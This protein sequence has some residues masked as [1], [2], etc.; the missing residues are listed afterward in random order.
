[1]KSKNTGIKYCCLLLLALIFSACSSQT[2][3]V[4][5]EADTHTSGPAE[6]VMENSAQKVSPT[7][8]LPVQYQNPRYIV[9]VDKSDEIEDEIDEIGLKVGANIV[10]TRGPEPLADVLRILARSKGF[11]I[12]WA[13]DVDRDVLVDVNIGANDDFHRSIENL[14]RQVDYFHEF[15]NN[16]LI[17]KYKETRQ[18]HVAMPFTAQ[19]Y[20]TGTGGNVLGGDSSNTEVDGTIELKSDNNEFDIWKN[21]QA[22]MD[23]IIAT[24]N[25]TTI[26][27]Q[28]GV[29]PAEE[30]E[31]EDEEAEEG[32]NEEVVAQA[33]MQVSSGDSMYIIDKP[34]GL[35]T[36]S[37]PRPLLDR[38]EAYFDS[39]KR[40]LYKQVNIEAKIIE[41][42]LVNDSDI[43][44][45]WSQVLSNFAING[46]IQFGEIGGT[47]WPNESALPF[48]RSVSL[49]G[50]NF[51]VFLNA[52]KT[53]G[54][55]HIL[56]N[57]RISVMNGQPALISVG[58]NTT[59]IDAVEADRD[60]V[61]NLTYSLKT[62]RIMSGV[63]LALTANILDD[64]EIIM[65][66]VPVTSELEEPIEYRKFGGLY[67][68]GLPIVNVREMSTTVKVRNGEMLVIGGLIDS[69]EQTQGEFAPVAGNI[70]VLR[71]LFGHEKKIRQKRELI[72]LLKPTIL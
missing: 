13:S 30:T 41:V 23:A 51:D 28:T 46:T 49:S 64:K 10:S 47:V 1:M 20:K 71:Y 12:S 59:Y 19:N 26:P 15:E 54:D 63:G 4:N 17:I 21:I 69:T 68:V 7:G 48:V 58:K 11:T 25:T 53:Q 44:I 42:Q 52:L 5:S 72:V 24:W 61:G 36:V 6:S 14:L 55:T 37:A 3:T 34:I 56:S 2:Q 43:G 70:P 8:A 39:L 50:A 18:F 27:G 65:N 16:T 38:I 31:N 9:D 40:E 66:L 45:N 60:D 33:A 29:T 22:N 62:E 35:V 67:E 32:E 57:P